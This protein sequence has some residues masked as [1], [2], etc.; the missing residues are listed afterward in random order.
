MSTSN[1]TTRFSTPSDTE[2]VAV[3]V[4]DAPRTL[5]WDVWT[6]PE[7]VRQWQLGPDGWTMPV[8][9]ID[10]RPGGRWHY[11]WRGDDGA[12]LSMTGEFR[13]VSPPERLVNTENWGGD[14]P[15]AVVTVEFTEDDGRTTATT[16]VVYPSKEAR[17]AATATGMK[18][19]WNAGLDRMAG[20]LATL[21]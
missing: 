3:R 20:Y 10:L 8:C 2:I 17:D 15:E 19:G 5:V 13:E 1:E 7:H 14:W 21:R 6:K 4:F 12:E 11:V 18:D 9:E 16:T